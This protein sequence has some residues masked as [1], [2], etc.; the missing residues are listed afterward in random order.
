MSIKAEEQISKATL[1]VS[2]SQATVQLNFHAGGSGRQICV[3]IGG[4][5]TCMNGKSSSLGPAVSALTFRPQRS[6]EVEILL[7]TCRTE[8]GQVADQAPTQDKW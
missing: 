2:G 6:L 3:L 4:M 5:V 8:I 1:H 7:K